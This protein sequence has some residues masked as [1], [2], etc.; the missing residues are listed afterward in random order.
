M[1]RTNWNSVEKS[2]KT[3]KRNVKILQQTGEFLKDFPEKGFM[4]DNISK[5][6]VVIKDC[7]SSSLRRYNKI[8]DNFYYL[9]TSEKDKQ[10][11]LDKKIEIEMELNSRNG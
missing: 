8:L 4:R 3:I 5:N 11:I 9:T 10:K 7:K 6:I 1:K 2:A